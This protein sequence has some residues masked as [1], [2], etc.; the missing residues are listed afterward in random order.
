MSTTRDVVALDL[1][2]VDACP[3]GHQDNVNRREVR[4]GFEIMC[5]SKDDVRVVQVEIG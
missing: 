1:V 3:S 4:P 2:C 5:V